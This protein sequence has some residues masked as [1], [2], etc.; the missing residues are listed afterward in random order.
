M[1]V[2]DALHAYQR[3][4]LDC[5]TADTV[6]QAAATIGIYRAL[7]DV[8]DEEVAAALTLLWGQVSAPV[9]DRRT[10]AVAQWL[11]WCVAS[12]LPAPAVPPGSR[13]I[14]DVDPPGGG[15]TAG[16]ERDQMKRRLRRFASDD[17]G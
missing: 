7:V 13:P 12:G 16:S 4:P 9:R 15:G 17:P 6:G 8:E 5:F 3:Q 2:L 10:A 14:R 1:L 11:A